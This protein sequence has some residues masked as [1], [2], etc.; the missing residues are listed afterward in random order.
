MITTKTAQKAFD[1]ISFNVLFI[2]ILVFGVS[3]I[4]CII[5]GFSTFHYCRGK[6]QTEMQ[7]KACK[8]TQNNLKSSGISLAVG[9]GIMSIGAI[10]S[11][12][13]YF[14]S[15]KRSSSMSASTSV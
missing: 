6:D 3:I 15:R 12:I 5:S 11:F 9:A 1:R 13:N 7:K 8:T 14:I 2:G 4:A 10:L